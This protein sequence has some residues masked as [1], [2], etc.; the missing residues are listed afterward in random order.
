MSQ[1]QESHS[2]HFL[3]ELDGSDVLYSHEQ[4]HKPGVS[5]IA[6]HLQSLG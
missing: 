6:R 5:L 4:V 2:P 1:D 3:V